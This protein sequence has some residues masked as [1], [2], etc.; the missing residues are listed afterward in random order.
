MRKVPDILKSKKFQMAIIGLVVTF[1]IKLVPELS[2]LEEELTKII[3][4]FGA[5][6]I[7]QG[8]SDFGKE[9]GK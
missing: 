7:A 3:S 2:E 4:L 5:F 6:I 1:I 8:L 9:A